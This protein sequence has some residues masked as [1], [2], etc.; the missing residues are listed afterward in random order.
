MRTTKRNLILNAAVEEA[1]AT[2][3]RMIT[4]RGVAERAHV[5]KSVVLYHFR[6]K[7]DL[8]RGVLQAAVD[9]REYAVIAAALVK[10]EPIIMRAP[11]EIR[12]AALNYL[13]NKT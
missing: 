3:Y 5:D 2:D 7:R 4:H 10:Q 9:Q 13:R 11:E 6:T 12:L 1:K 8:K